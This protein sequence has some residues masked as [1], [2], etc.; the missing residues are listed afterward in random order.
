MD[1]ICSFYFK[2]CNAWPSGI[3]VMF[4]FAVSTCIVAML[5]RPYRLIDIFPEIE[6]M[7][8]QDNWS[9]FTFAVFESITVLMFDQ[10][11]IA[12]YLSRFDG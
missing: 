4:A 9:I 11:L 3:E 2:S 10:P 8:Q 1:Y 5:G 12:E 7:L 6:V